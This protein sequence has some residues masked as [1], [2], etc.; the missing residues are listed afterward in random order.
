MWYWY[1]VSGYITSSKHQAKMYQL[2]GL[3]SGNRS[4]CVVAIV[5]DIRDVPENAR[6]LLRDFMAVSESSQAN[7]AGITQ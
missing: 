5:T 6:E 1:N 3:F 2:L 7:F 4:A